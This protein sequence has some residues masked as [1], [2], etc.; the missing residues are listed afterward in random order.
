MRWT[1]HRNVWNRYLALG[2]AGVVSMLW[3]ATADQ[4]ALPG[5]GSVG[6][7]TLIEAVRSAL[8][9]QSQI[10][11]GVQQNEI[12]RGIALVEAGAFD[13]VLAAG[14][15]ESRIY[16]PLTVLGKQLSIQAGGGRPTS[17][18]LS[19]TSFNVGAKRLFRNGV[20]VGALH[21]MNRF[22]D[23]L[24]NLDGLSTSNSSFVVTIPLLQGRGRAAVDAAEMAARVEQDATLLDLNQTIAEQ[25]AKTAAD[26]WNVVAALRA[27]QVA[28]ASE[29]RGRAL[30]E[31][32]QLLIDADR[33][34]RNDMTSVMANL[35]DRTARRINAQQT[36]VAARQVLAVDMGLNSVQPPAMG[37]PAEDFPAGEQTALP[38]EDPRSVTRYVS[39][40]M[41]QRA[42][43]LAAQR[44]RDES[45]IRARA[46]E[47]LLLPRLDVSVSTGYSGLSE[48]R[49]IGN[50]LVSPFRDAQ[51]MD[52]IGGLQFR[53]PVGNRTARG[54]AML[55]AA[56]VRQSNVRIEEVSRAVT[57]DVLTAIFNVRNS[58][59]R[60]G[61]TRQSV[62]S[63]ELA[64]QGERDKFKL[65]L[66][67]VVDILTVEDR[68]TIALGNR[69]DAQLRYALAII[70]LRL[71]TGTIVSPG[72]AAKTIG[73]EVFVTLP[74]EPTAVPAP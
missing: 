30:V 34:A 44:R 20:S 51:G 59:M 45:E 55:A 10:Q 63:F 17:Q 15:S 46:T 36:A 71:A 65:G 32:T 22:S 12:A 35:A 53:F 18:T 21:Q 54:E 26:Y 68:L 1:T 3:S 47:N 62:E 19:G 2:L 72:P 58:I 11:L 66:N 41:L 52:V 64:L 9:H 70:A 5:A 61:S 48:G 25:L 74:P 39:G 60:L 42:D 56:V 73:R 38:S 13:T 50:A 43:L 69:V 37:Y 8:A 7:L 6:S 29:A 16:A 27:V 31:N 14:L 57:A 40:S 23:N 4:A 67:S 33:T 24:S 28:E 49:S